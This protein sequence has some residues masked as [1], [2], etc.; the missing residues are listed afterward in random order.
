MVVGYGLWREAS[1]THASPWPH[2]VRLVSHECI[3][4]WNNVGGW[5]C[6]QCAHWMSGR[7]VGSGNMR[8]RC[9]RLMVVVMRV[10]AHWWPNEM[11]R[12]MRL[13]LIAVCLC[14]CWWALQLMIARIAGFSQSIELRTSRRGRRRCWTSVYL[15]KM[16]TRGSI[17][18]ICAR[19]GL[20][21]AISNNSY[22]ERILCRK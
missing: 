4:G 19:R 13:W 2:C 22:L 11:E 18:D 5:V 16:L 21:V 3:Y 10:V 17:R 7:A 14:V 9:F 6:A 8:L 20:S 1:A 12:F 15:N